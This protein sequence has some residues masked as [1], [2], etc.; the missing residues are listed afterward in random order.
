MAPVVPPAGGAPAPLWQGPWPDVFR[1]A[2]DVQAFQEAQREVADRRLYLPYVDFLR[3]LGI[4]SVRGHAIFVDRA[5]QM[6]GGGAA[7]WI[8]RVA[9]PVRSQ[10]ELRRA[11]AH[12]GHADLRSFQAAPPEG[13]GV[14]AATGALDALTHAAL[15]AA[16]RRRGDS[17]LPLR[18]EEQVLAALLAEADRQA[19]ASPPWR[20]AATRMRALRDDPAL[21]R[22]PGEPPRGAA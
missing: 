22:L 10:E 21:A 19:G 7:R 1:A 8:A 6:G 16:L 11:L 4:D 15:A 13:I 14:P 5:L 9:G 3:W 12:L 17:P 2:G 18:S 20:A